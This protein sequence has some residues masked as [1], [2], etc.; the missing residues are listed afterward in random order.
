MRENGREEEKREKLEPS[1][2][3]L[4]KVKSPI[5]VFAW[6]LNTAPKTIQI[7]KMNKSS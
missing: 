7:T 1:V 6:A 2:S 5:T 4:P 3:L